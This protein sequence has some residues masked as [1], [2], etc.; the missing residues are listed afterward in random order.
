MRNVLDSGR[1]RALHQ[2]GGPHAMD[3]YRGVARSKNVG[4]TGTRMTSTC[5]ERE[6]IT[7]SGD[8]APIG[9]QGQTPLQVVGGSP[10]KLKTF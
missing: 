3:D 4:W 1:S 7:G 6:P 8:G 2:V 5:T 10:L 9:V